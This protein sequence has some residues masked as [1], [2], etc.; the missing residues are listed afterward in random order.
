V[1]LTVGYMCCNYIMCMIIRKRISWNYCESQVIVRY[2][3]V[4][5]TFQ[6]N[7]FLVVVALLACQTSFH[8]NCASKM[9]AIER[10]FDLP[11][12]W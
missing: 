11:M 8:I 9:V 5:I 10:G 4:Q 3:I 2:E 6:V 1:V 12:W 7:Y